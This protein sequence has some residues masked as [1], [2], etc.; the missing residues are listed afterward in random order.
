MSPRKYNSIEMMRRI[1]FPLG[2]KREVITIA[3]PAK[4]ENPKK[5]HCNK[6]KRKDKENQS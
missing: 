6:N 2:R 5:K 3:C 1:I 4:Q